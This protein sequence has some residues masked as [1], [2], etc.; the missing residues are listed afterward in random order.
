MDVI[1][2]DPQCHYS[3]TSFT[4]PLYMIPVGKENV[5]K[6]KCD[7]KKKKRTEGLNVNFALKYT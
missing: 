1:C 2:M 3:G 5:Y 7:L 4:W 6:K